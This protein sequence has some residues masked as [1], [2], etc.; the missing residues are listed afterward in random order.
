MGAAALAVVGPGDQRGV[1][2]QDHGHIQ[3]PLEP[4]VATVRK[5]ERCQC[6]SIVLRYESGSFG[7]ISSTC[8][9]DHQGGHR[10]DNHGIDKGFQQGHRALADRFIGLGGRVGNGRRSRAGLVGKDGPLDTYHQDPDKPSI[11]RIRVEGTLEDTDDRII[12]EEEFFPQDEKGGQHVGTAHEGDDA[13]SHGANRTDAS[14]DHDPDQEGHHQ[15]ID[16]VI[17]IEKWD[18]LL[19]GTERLNHLEGVP[20]AQR[21]PDANDR[22]EAYLPFP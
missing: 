20:P 16:P 10:A 21:C 7:G 13:S 17:V 14:N 4:R 22:K 12:N 5:C 6:G 15:A 8:D 19:D 18:I 1:T 3:D 9:N 11:N 2:E